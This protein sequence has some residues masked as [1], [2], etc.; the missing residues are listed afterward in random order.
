MCSRWSGDFQYET[1]N[2]GMITQ[3]TSTNRPD[4]SA[5]GDV[6]AV[7]RAT[8]LIGDAWSWLVLREAVLYDAR[9]LS[10]FLTGT[11]AQR[12]TLALLLAA[13]TDAGLLSGDSAAYV[14]TPIA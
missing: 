13:L 6:D 10:D 14:S 3:V 1:N 2:E 8:D 7:F 5:V 12:S 9:R 11:G 4:A